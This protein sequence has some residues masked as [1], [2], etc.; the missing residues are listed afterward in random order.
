MYH[1]IGTIGNAK[2][3]YSA[4]INGKVVA[5]AAFGRP[6]RY[7]S[8]LRLKARTIELT[9]FCIHPQYHK[10]NFASWLLARLEKIVRNDAKFDVMLAFS[11]PLAGHDGTIYSAAN[12]EFD[13]KTA[14][15]YYYVDNDGYVMHKKTLYNYAIKFRMREAEYASRHGW[16]KVHVPP[17]NRYIKRRHK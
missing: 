10:K 8:E 12:W 15:S 6:T 17:K 14:P 9:R 16:T 7:E 1:Y 13:G 3:V 5:V 11:D 2:Y 4:T